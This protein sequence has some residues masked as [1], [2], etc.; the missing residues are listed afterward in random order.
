MKYQI[1]LKS[2]EFRAFHGCYEMEQ[3]VGNRFRVDMQITTELGDLADSDDVSHAVNYLSLYEIV[4]EQMKVTNNTIE[5]VAARIIDAVKR[6]YP[7]IEQVSVEVAKIAP[8]LG[9]KIAEVSVV[10]EG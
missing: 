7:S 2:M 10:L 3:R 1:R 5:A 9:G 8:P 4:S 6:A